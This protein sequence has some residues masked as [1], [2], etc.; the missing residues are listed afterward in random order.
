MH[1]ECDPEN[2]SPTA[3]AFHNALPG[4]PDFRGG[5]ASEVQDFIRALNRIA[6]ESGKSQDSRW[7]AELASTAFSGEALR[8]FRSLAPKVQVDW[9]VIQTAL[10]KQYAPDEAIKEYPEAEGDGISLDSTRPTA[11]EARQV[12]FCLHQ[13]SIEQGWHFRDDVDPCRR[14]TRQVYSGFQSTQYRNTELYRT[15]RVLGGAHCN[16]ADRW[17]KLG[18]GCTGSMALTSC[19]ADDVQNPASARLNWDTA[20]QRAPIHSAIW[21]VLIDGTLIAQ[22]Y[23]DKVWYRLVVAWTPSYL[24]ELYLVSD[25]DSFVASV[26]QHQWDQARLKFEPKEA[27]D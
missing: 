25:F 18:P 26:P 12:I 17:Y 6:L 22:V 9:D 4:V 19:T 11:D 21:S 20:P 23:R 3:V 1:L 8:W 16:T 27:Y 15:L 5:G 14:L 2:W 13:S 10:L 7:K 24:G